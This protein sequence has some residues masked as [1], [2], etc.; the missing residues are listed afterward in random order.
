MPPKTAKNRKTSKNKTEKK[1]RKEQKQFNVDGKKFTNTDGTKTRIERIGGKE[2]NNIIRHKE[3]VW[4]EE[5][6]ILWDELKKKGLIKYGVMKLDGKPKPKTKPKEKPKTK[7]K[8]K[9]K[10]K[11]KTKPKEKEEKEEKEEKKEESQT[12]ELELSCIELI[13]TLQMNVKNITLESKEYQKLLKCI[14]NK[15]KEE[16]ENEGDSSLY[17][18][19]DDPNFTKK[20]SLKKEFDDVKIEEKTREEINNIEEVSNKLCSASIPFELEPYQ[21]FVR[22]FLSFQTPYNGLLLFHGLGT[23]KTCS[24]IQV[25]EDMRTYYLQLGIKK[26]IIIVASP[27]V[28]EN[29]KLQLFDDRKLKL[30]NGLWNLKSCTGNKFIKEV[31]P[32]NMK[33]LPKWKV[34]KQIEKIRRQ[35]YEFLGYTEFANKINKIIKSSKGNSKDPQ[36][37]TQRK[38]NAIRKLFSDRMLVIDEIHN[39]R[40]T[41]TSKKG[42]TRRTIKNLTDLVMYAQ[43]M[44]LLLLTATPMFNDYREIIWLTNLLNLNDNR[45][46]ISI[47]D[48]FDKKGNFLKNEEKEIG[49]NL[50][51]QKLT[52]YVSYVSGENPFR[53]PYRI[54]P[55]EANNPHSLKKLL[56]SS[57]WEYPK[58]QI[59]TMEINQPIIHLDLVITSLKEDQDK[60]YNFIIEKTREV[61]PEL[62]NPNKGIQYTIID[63]P[64]QALN[65]VYPNKDIDTGSIDYKGLYG[66]TGLRRLM[67]YDKDNFKQ[68]QYSQKTLTNY[69]RLFNS[70][71][72]ENSPLRKYSAKIYSIINTI[73]NSDGIILV[74]STYIFGGCVPIALALEE[75]GITRYGDKSKSLF[76]TPPKKSIGKYV[77]ITGDK[78]FSP[79]NKKELKAC[80]DENNINGENIKVIIIS[81]AGSEGLDFKN[82]RQ[83]HI[84]DPWYN[85]NRADQTIGR[86]VRNKSHCDLPFNKRNVEI[87][88][89]GSQLINKEIEPIDLYVYRLAEKKSM[90]IGKVTRLLKETS[91]DCLININQKDI[92]ESN[93]NKQVELELSTKQKIK[94]NVGYKNNSII[95]DFMNCD[96][97]CFPVDS[98][99]QNNISTKSYS[100][101]YIIMNL[102]KILKRIKTL[103]NEHY[104]YKKGELIKRINAVKHY[105]NE[106]INMALNVLLTDKNELLVDMLNRNGRLVNID[107]LYLFQ[108]IEL[109]NKHIPEYQRKIP[110]DVKIPSLNFQLDWD[111][112]LEKNEPTTTTTIDTLLKLQINYNLSITPQVKSKNKNWISSAP[113]VIENLNKF[114]GIDKDIL[115]GFCLEHLFDILNANDKLAV[116]NGLLINSSDIENNFKK[117]LNEIINNKYIIINKEK[118]IKGFVCADYKQRHQVKKSKFFWYIFIFD[119]ENKK[120]IKDKTK[121]PYIATKMFRRWKGININKY[122]EKIFGFLTSNKRKSAIIFKTKSIEMGKKEKGQECPSKG[123]NRSAIL[124]RINDLTKQLPFE[125]RE[126]GKGFTD[127]LKDKKDRKDVKKEFYELDKYR[128]KKSSKRQNDS[129]YGKNTIKQYHSTSEKIKENEIPLTDWQLCIETEFLLRY[130][131]E[132]DPNE[133]RWFFSTIE[134]VLNQIRNI[135]KE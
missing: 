46:P 88:L 3:D 89:Y 82:I 98:I 11:P 135:H 48:V 121:V 95:C 38:K 113:W 27:V 80:T 120:W 116:I 77:M 14:E 19:L 20:I 39:V 84:L 21:M 92:I 44:K 33:G 60:Y 71:D 35:S 133:K 87:F 36:I 75:I 112:E 65:I 12:H 41:S 50:L 55:E 110:I 64:Q 100:K 96:Y 7:P 31:N 15:N 105:S 66:K 40:T 130:L 86:A 23:G 9:P 51:I 131:D 13:K 25:C 91:V 126:K 108:P 69:G 4:P 6:N 67:H 59:N 45:F 122:N 32:M 68:F 104:V 43:N 90:Q 24:S 128:M 119:K 85:L 53:F 54:W 58:K 28:Q 125:T 79:S 94:F 83:V 107:D 74:Y 93:M 26:K 18:I 76:K 124:A 2:S 47:S 61:H 81:R 103:F 37:I 118:D 42:N 129:I 10:T 62:N 109:D 132:N 1:K 29:Y 102:E 127:F 63:A 16:I 52:G 73:K 117:K 134:D 114:D 70:D 30:I 78:H 57:S 5:A 97:N 101:S 111:I 72:S 22:N 99:D 123:E 106:Q 56:K 17:P 115:Q 34:I 8:E 49:K